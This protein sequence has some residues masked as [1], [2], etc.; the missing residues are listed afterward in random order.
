[1]KQMCGCMVFNNFDSIFSVNHGRYLLIG[2]QLPAFH[3]Y[4]VKVLSIWCFLNI[5]NESGHPVTFKEATVRYLTSAFCV[6]RSI[7]KDN[8]YFLTYSSLFNKF[9]FFNNG[10]YGRMCV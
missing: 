4:L 2:F 6:E 1:M 7:V 3:N 9:T 10:Y 8:L 5:L